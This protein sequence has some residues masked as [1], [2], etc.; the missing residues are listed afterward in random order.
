MKIY[1]SFIALI[2]A[3]ILPAV[4]MA[5]CSPYS[6]KAPDLYAGDTLTP[7]G[8]ESIIAAVSE[9]EA[10]T[11]EK[12]IPA[13]DESGAELLFWTESGKVWHISRE[14]SAL[15]RSSNIL[16]GNRSAAAEAGKERA[17]SVCGKGG[18]SDK[19]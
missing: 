19:G 7:E 6:A 11:T 15:K 2:A 4:F 8:L 1:R 12:Y 5:A 16:S 13:T 3:L 10:E 18:Q 9:K 17:C 14:C